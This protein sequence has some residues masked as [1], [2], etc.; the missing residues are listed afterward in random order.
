[1]HH[2]KLFIRSFLYSTS[3]FIKY[4]K[5]I[6]NCVL[7]L[8]F[9]LSVFESNAQIN[10]VVLDS[11]TTAAIRQTTVINPK[12]LNA[13]WPAR[14][15]HMNESQASPKDYGVYHF[16]K[17]I[18]LKFIPKKYVIHVSADNRY[19]LYVNGR[20]IGEGP[21]RGDLTHWSFGSYDLAPY[22]KVGK[23]VLAAEVWNMGTFA[24]VAQ[25]FNETGFLVQ[26][27][28]LQTVDNHEQY[29]IVN[30]FNTDASWKVMRDSAYS[31]TALN[32]G[33]VLHSYFVTGT[34][35]RVAG[36]NFPW[37]WQDID[38]DD[39]HWVKATIIE[40]PVA[41]A[42]Y[43]TDNQWTLVPRS[44][45]Q[46]EHNLEPIGTIRRIVLEGEKGKGTDSGLATSMKDAF[47]AGKPLLIAPHTKMKILIDQGYETVGYPLLKLS[48]GRGAR[49]KLT[50]TEALLDK[51][52]QKGNR[53]VIQRKA[54][55]GLYD[56][57]L[58]DGGKDRIYQPLWLRTFRYVELDIETK[59]EPIEIK[60]FQNEFAAYPFKRI[61]SFVSN[62][63]SLSEIWKVGW[64]T[65][66]L[67]AGETYFDCPY[68]EQLQYEADTRIQALITLYNSNDDRL[69][70]KAINDFYL[71]LTPEGLTQGRYPSSRFQVIP[72]FSLWWVTMLHDY[73]M[74]RPD[75]KFI[76]SYL[77]GV[78]QVLSWFENRINSNTQMLGPLKWWNFVDWNPAFG[79]GVP[80]GAT[81]GQS[82]IITLQYV[83]ALQ[84]ASD[85]L[86]DYGDTLQ[87]RHYK[88]LAEKLAAA[89][90][91]SCFDFKRH[92]MA[93]N[94]EKTAYSQHASILGILTDAIPVG[95]QKEV[96]EE[97]LK[98]KNL[99]QVTFYY[100]FY[101][102]RAMVKAGLGDDYYATLTT[103]RDMLNIGL[104]T[105]A[106]KPE[107]TRSD[108][109][110]WSASPVF[111]FLATICG[112]TSSAPGFSVVEIAPH[113]G[114]LQHVKGAMPSP[115]GMIKVV[116]KRIGTKDI[117]SHELNA[118]IE[119]PQGLYGVFKWE[120]KTYPIKP[121]S[122]VI[123]TQ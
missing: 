37:G 3:N 23:N 2:N 15:V 5:P 41:P 19:R 12:L 67:C 100:R 34:G 63:S 65:A 101:L 57:Y 53:N 116:L 21:A 36:V 31:P 6:F 90:Y 112:I 96:M 109:H 56:I 73:W 50:Y 35:D 98:D 24:P 44:I 43:G 75:R 69:V 93:D 76:K 8:L 102:T 11:S 108:C 68:Y 87:S 85:L 71:S 62:D 45:P 61:A 119:L 10:K 39:S 89:T 106:E 111:D 40:T 81:T 32:V 72:P 46:M 9:C 49:V 28:S 104:T 17:A 48:S 120:G 51:N 95:D 91:N 107:P 77:S 14:W 84:Q 122:Q 26:V 105:F 42:G 118:R 64:R 52:E 82:S 60:S 86:A 123:Q 110:G 30:N 54:V 117:T 88:T 16:R 115:H 114:A 22:L 74:L 97:I 121:G 25:I 78:Q 13:T 94:R 103:W 1:M 70:R 58:P 38:Y 55:K 66:R 29:N 27:D 7:L 92:E 113:L 83:L 99:S 20:R 79:G 33:G 80:D 47:G 4:F 59:G 18:V